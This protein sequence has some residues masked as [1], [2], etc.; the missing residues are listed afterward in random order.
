[1]SYEEEV[2]REKDAGLRRDDKGE[3]ER[4]ATVG[5]EE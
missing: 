1:V 5:E 4:V 3:K 2:G